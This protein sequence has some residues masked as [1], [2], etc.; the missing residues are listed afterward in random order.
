MLQFNTHI[1]YL[2][3][4]SKTLS[5]IQKEVGRVNGVFSE[6]ALFDWLMQENPFIGIILFEALKLILT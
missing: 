1:N 5:S 6:N 4:N 3:P 2:V